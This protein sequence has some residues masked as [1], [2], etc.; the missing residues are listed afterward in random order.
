MELVTGITWRAELQRARVIAP[1]RASVWFRQLLDGLQFAHARGIVH[2]DLKPEN[3]MITDMPPDGDLKITDFGL[4]KVVDAGPGV[5]ESVTAAG[6][7]LGTL[8]YMAPELLTG[9]FVDE[10]ADLLAVGV[11]VVETVTGRRPFA[12]QTAQEILLAV[13]HSEYHLPATSAEARALDTVV[14]R[15]L[16]K[17]PRDRYRTAAELA[18][19]LVPAVV[20]WRGFESPDDAIGRDSPTM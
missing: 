18:D 13:I 2:R 7:T 16:A 1:L 14:Q 20:R 6:T 3:V 8:G 5:T 12:G 19:D 15:C 9:G 10:R 4:A 17:D 11:M